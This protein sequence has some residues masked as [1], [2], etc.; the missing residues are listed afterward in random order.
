MAT[1]MNSK[2][3]VWHTRF[4]GVFPPWISCVLAL[5]A[6]FV[7]TGTVP[8]ILAIL[9]DSTASTS[10]DKSTL[11]AP[12]IL[13]NTSNAS[14]SK[15]LLAGLG[16]DLTQAPPTADATPSKMWRNHHQTRA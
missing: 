8:M 9:R 11:W 1:K 2:R 5:V 4:T 14:L 7:V 13:S 6:V 12:E 10:S 16:G 3:N 15:F